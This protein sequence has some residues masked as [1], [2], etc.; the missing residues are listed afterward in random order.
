MIDRDPLKF[1][2]ALAESSPLLIQTKAD[3]VFVQHEIENS[4]CKIVDRDPLKFALALAE[5]S[6]LLTKD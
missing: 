1:A 2:L 4:Q 5:S 3:V 6:P